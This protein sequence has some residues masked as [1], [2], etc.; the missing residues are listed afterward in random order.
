M[1]LFGNLFGGGGSGKRG[2]TNLLTAALAHYPPNTPPH[3]G[4]VKK[5]SL[6]EAE[7]N[8]AHFIAN[9]D[10]RLTI[11]LTMLG[12][13]GIDMA[14]VLDAAADPAPAYRAL[15]AWL[16][17]NL[18]TRDAL[19]G[20]SKTNAPIDHYVASERRGDDIFY[21]FV[22]DLALLEGEGV[23]RRDPA[24]CWDLDRDPTD[25]GTYAYRRVALARGKQGERLSLALDLEHETL[26]LLYAMRAPGH[27]AGHPLGRTLAGVV[28]G[29]F[30]S[31]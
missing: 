21:S 14:P 12:D 30:D 5:L 17:D 10:E 6:A 15:S 23:I 9:R 20:E 29:R 1:S 31:I 28:E 3:P 11:L 27:S 24:W 25:A 19:P 2:E 18:P 8:L 22:A 13:N 7:A 4:P 16:A 26:E